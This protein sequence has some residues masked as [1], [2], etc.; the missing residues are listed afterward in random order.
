MR[1]LLFLLLSLPLLSF[2]DKEA[3]SAAPFPSR[4]DI[5]YLAV[6]QGLVGVA[7]PASLQGYIVRQDTRSNDLYYIEHHHLNFSTSGKIAASVC[8]EFARQLF[9][10]NLKDTW[11]VGR[12]ELSQD[13]KSACRIVLRDRDKKAELRE[14]ILSVA[15][16][17]GHDEGFVAKFVH[18]PRKV[19][20]QEFADFIHSLTHPRP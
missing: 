6:G 17:Q 18:F 9:G 20:V 2:A 12:A 13:K 4:E 5:R 3:L 1:F 19:D 11:E 16:V 8:L 10:E 7:E 15:L 14:R